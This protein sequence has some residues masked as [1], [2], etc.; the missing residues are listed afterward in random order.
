MVLSVTQQSALLNKVT[1]LWSEVT[2]VWTMVALN[3]LAQ[4]L[5]SPLD[6]P[7]RGL[8]ETIS[9]LHMATTLRDVIKVSVEWL[10]MTD[11]IMSPASV[12]PVRYSKSHPGSQ[13]RPCLSTTP[14]HQVPSYY[15]VDSDVL[16][17]AWS[18]KDTS[19]HAYAIHAYSSSG[20]AGAFG[21]WLWDV[22]SC[23]WRYYLSSPFVVVHAFW[24][25]CL[26]F[27]IYET[28]SPLDVNI[29]QL[30]VF[31]AYLI[32]KYIF[33]ISWEQIIVWM[34]KTAH[35]HIIFHWSCVILNCTWQMHHGGEP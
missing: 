22:G 24:S 14:D 29:V 35:Q 2:A 1:K 5:H 7:Q 16:T 20:Y 19:M 26:T 17:W 11:M 28:R 18:L 21:D 31:I 23:K 32:S 25:S 34:T 10:D 13:I 27:G 4:N 8:I 15:H 12:P 3:Q 9:N 33:S 6:K 30:K